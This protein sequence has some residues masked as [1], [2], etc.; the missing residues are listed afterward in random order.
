MS[1]LR[2]AE[3]TR[4]SPKAIV[5]DLKVEMVRD[6]YKAGFSLSALLERMCPKE[7]GDDSGLDAYQRCLQEAEI[8]T[9]SLPQ[10]GIVADTWEEAFHATPARRLLGL[11]WCA[12]QWRAVSHRPRSSNVATR[13]PSVMTSQ[14]YTIGSW[15][16]PFADAASYRLQQI[17]PAIPLSELIA[18]T[19]PIDT[20]VYRAVYIED[21][22]PTQKRMVRVGETAEIPRVQFKSTQRDITLYKYGRGIESSYEVLRRQRLD[23]VAIEL[24]LMAVQVESDKVA[25]VLDVLVNGDGNSN[26]APVTNLTTLDPDTIA[27]NPTLAAWI[28]A[29]MLFKNPYHMTA[30]LGQQSPITKAMLINTGSANIPLMVVS[31]FLGIGGFRLLNNTLA[32]TV[33]YGITEDAPANKWVTVDT[34]FAIERVYEIGSNITEVEKFASKQTEALFMTEV[35]GYA[36]LDKRAVNVVDLNA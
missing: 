15:E 22:D 11:E 36:K 5:E 30:M 16:K 24:A 8:Y 12:R 6:A 13:D 25:T 4:M 26:P 10:D 29:K 33:A 14:D 9:R 21:I 1:K 19:T 2:L 18:V 32:D 17:A 27:G 7:A 20:N 28:A 34:R 3:M 35:E 23:R 31:S